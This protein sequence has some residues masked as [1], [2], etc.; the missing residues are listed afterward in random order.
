AIRRSIRY[1]QAR[2]AAEL[3]VSEKTLQ[4]W[5]LG[6]KPLIRLSFSKLR[7]LQRSLIM[8]GAPAEMM[9]VWDTALAVDELLDAFDTTAPDQHPLAMVVPDRATTDLLSWAITGQLPR[10]L[11]GSAAVL[12]IPAVERDAAAAALRDAADHATAGSAESAQLRRQ[13]MYL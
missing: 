12:H 3:D 11:H 4:G 1:S 6:T 10:E 13:V 9:H 2:L 7:R 5:E 8:L